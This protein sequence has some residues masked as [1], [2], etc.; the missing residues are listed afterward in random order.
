MASGT[1]AHRC[2]LCIPHPSWCTVDEMG[3]AVD[4]SSAAGWWFIFFVVCNWPSVYCILPFLSPTPKINL[5]QAPPPPR[6]MRPVPA[7]AELAMAVSVNTQAARGSVECHSFRRF[8]CFFR[9]SDAGSSGYHFG[10]H[11]VNN[12]PVLD[13]IASWSH[14]FRSLLD[15][16]WPLWAEASDRNMTESWYTIGM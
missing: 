9:S 2:R 7:E 3:I 13:G 1:S 11:P 10:I 6:W 14:F 15:I 5:V 16:C 4:L 12:R 8:E